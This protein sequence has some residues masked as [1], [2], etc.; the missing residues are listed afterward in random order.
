M[1]DYQ[2]VEYK[3][4]LGVQN[5]FAV[6]PEL[7]KNNSILKNH[8]VQFDGLMVDWGKLI[9]QQNF[10]ISG[11]ASEKQKAKT[12]LSETIFGLTSSVHSFAVDTKNDILLNEFDLSVSHINKLSDV[13]FVAY[14][15]NLSHT[16]EENKEALKPYNVTADEL[17]NLTAETNSYSKL[18]LKPAEERKER[19][20]V[21]ANVK[22]VITKVLTL[23]SDSIDFDMEHYKDAEPA[24]YEKYS[25]LREIDD[26]ATH[27]LSIMGTVTDADSDCDG[28]EDGCALAHVKVIAKFKPGKAWKESHAVTSG[29]GNY[30]FKDIPDGKCTV[31]FTLEY[32][33]TVTKEIAVYSNKATKLDVEMKKTLKIV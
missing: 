5:F 19:A 11:Y 31:I 25:K 2:E 3:M 24:I 22:K 16:L 33:D 28:T 9:D 18:L 23:L 12:A 20:I 8:L 29:L 26:S 17:V 4:A 32:Y 13:K 6:N 30:Q 1:N 21:T 10:D 7:T 15:T 14:S 27:A